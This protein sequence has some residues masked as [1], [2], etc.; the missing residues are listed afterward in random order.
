MAVATTPTVFI[1]GMQA[2]VAAANLTFA[3]LYQL[4][5]TLPATLAPGDYPI[6]AQI[7]GMRSADNL[8]LSIE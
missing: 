7:G 8:Y 1:G 5:V 2:T 3:G 6:V 4:N